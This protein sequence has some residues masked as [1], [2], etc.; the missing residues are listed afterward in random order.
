VTQQSLTFNRQ[1][2]VVFGGKDMSIFLAILILIGL[3][4]VRFGLPIIIV[5]G[6][7]MIQDRYRKLAA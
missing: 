1:S 4:T 3:F 6:F 2:L 7:G 5:M